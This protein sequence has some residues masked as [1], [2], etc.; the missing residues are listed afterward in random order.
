[1]LKSFMRMQ[2]VDPGFQPHNTLAMTVDLPG[3]VYNTPARLRA[4]HDR[5]LEET[6]RHA[7]RGLCRSGELAAARRGAHP[8]RFHT[9]RRPKTSKGFIADKVTVSPGYFRTLGIRVLAGRDF[10]RARFVRRTRRG[11]RQPVAGAAHLAGRGRRGQAHMPSRSRP[12]AKDWL[13]VI[14]VAA[15][16]R[17]S[18][19][20]VQ[21]LTGHLPAVPA[22]VASR[23]S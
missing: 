20:T 2:A 10:E 3:S 15:D 17:Q 16:I 12:E 4:F 13:T 7:G 9:R 5:L 11:D 18:E 23:S 6:L 19:L 22:N 1:M 14:A 8:R 21:S